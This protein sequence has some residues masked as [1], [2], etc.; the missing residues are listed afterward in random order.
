MNLQNV[1]RSTLTNDWSPQY[2]EVKLE[3]WIRVFAH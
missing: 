3:M 2:T 1:D